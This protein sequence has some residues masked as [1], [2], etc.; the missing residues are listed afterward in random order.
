MKASYLKIKNFQQSMKKNFMTKKNY[1][2]IL[3]ALSLMI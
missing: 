3:E 2:L 1:L